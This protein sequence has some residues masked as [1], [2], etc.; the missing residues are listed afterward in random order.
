MNNPANKSLRFDL[1]QFGLERFCFEMTSRGVPLKTRDDEPVIGRFFATGCQSRSLDEYERK[2]LV[3]QFTGKGYVWTNLTGRVGFESQ[4]VVEY[5]PDFLMQEET[6]YVYFRPQRVDAISFKTTLVE[7]FI[8]QGGIAIT[9][10]DPNQIGR[11]IVTSQLRRGFTVIRLDETG[12]MQ[13]GLG[14]VPRG[15]HPFQ[16]FR[17]ASE[18]RVTLANDRT[19]VHPGQQDYIGGFK[20][21]ESGQALYMTVKM[22]GTD[23]IDVLLVP[24]AQ[25]DVMIQGYVT[26]PG[27]AIPTSP[28]RLLEPLGSGVLWQRYVPVSPGDYFVVLDHSAAIVPSAPGAQALPAKVDYAIQLG[29][30]P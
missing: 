9:G 28:P 17:V 7:S 5:A 2:S 18:S 27:P 26:N 11:E 16:P 3:V 21:E 8:A 23:S 4:G 22:D 20:V 6:L 14:Y 30:T 1:L 29:S 25:G 15:R 13:F 24:K 10:T 19:V 12:E